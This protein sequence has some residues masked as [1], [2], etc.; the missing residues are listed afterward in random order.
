[1]PSQERLLRVQTSYFIAGAVWAK[2]WG[3]WSCVETAP[4]LHWM[5]NM[6][7]NEAKNA[8]LRMGAS[9][10]WISS[11]P[12]KP[13]GPSTGHQTTRCLDGTLIIVPRDQ[14]TRNREKAPGSYTALSWPAYR[15]RRPAQPRGGRSRYRQP[16]SGDRSRFAPKT[17]R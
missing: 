2:I 17:R 11:S 14:I 1:M 16:G 6:N 12:P 5:K 9:F 10:Q 13:C 7:T 3:L 8:L 4:I 15:Y